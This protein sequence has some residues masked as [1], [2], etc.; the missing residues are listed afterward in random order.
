[1]IKD[2]KIG[3]RMWMFVILIGFA[4]QLAWAIENMY[5]NTYITYI[6]F[7]APAGE[8]FSYSSF[9]AITTALSAVVA[10]LTTILMGALTDKI[11]HK[12]YFISI[13][14]ILWG[15][16]T[17]AFGIFNV[18]STSKILPIAMV[19]SLAAIWVILLD[20]LMTFFGSTANDAAFNS[21]ITKNI[22][23]KNKGKVEG[24]LQILPLVAMLL[25]F[26]VLNGF[27]IDSKAGVHDAKW[28]LFFYL[29]GGLVL[30]MGILSFFLIPKEDEKKEKKSYLTELT[31]GFTPSVI[32]KNKNLYL[33]FIIYFIYAAAT[34]IFFPYLMIYL[35]Y[36]CGI[37]NTGT[38]FLTPFAIVMAVALLLGSLLSVLFGFAS[39]KVGKNK[40]II[41]TFIIYGIGIFMMFFI[42][43]VGQEQDVGRTIYGAIAGMIMILGYVGVPT[44]INAIVREKI[45]QG[46]EG[47]FMGV[48]MLFVVAFP[49]CIGPFIGDALNNTTGQSYVNEFGDRSIFPSEYGYLVGLGVLVLAILPILFYLKREKQTNKN[50]GYLFKDREHIEI[51]EKEIPL[52]SYPRPNMV[53]DSY[54]NL[55][56]MWDFAINKEE[57]I[58]SVYYDHIM[59][60]F[61]VES[62]YS[63]INHLVEP[64]E[65]MYY[66]KKVVFPKDFCKEK[67]VIH[68][69]GVDQICEVYINNQFVGKHVGGF[70]PFEIKVP[71][72]VKEEMDLV[73]KVKD[74]TDSSY[75]SRG[76]QVLKVTDFFY[77]SSSGVY[78]PVWM[79]SYPK[80]SIQEVKFT[81]DYDKKSVRVK[82]MTPVNRKAKL[83]LLNEEYEIDTNNDCEIDLSAN[84]HPWSTKDPYLY[85]VEIRYQEDVIKSY[86]GIRKIEIKNIDGK[87]RILL[88]DEPIFISGLLD[89]GYYFIGNYTPKTYDEY[90]FDIRKTKE[91]GFNCLRKH[92]KT[93]LPMFYYYCDKEG[94]LVIQDFP[95]GG[96]QYSFFWTVVPRALSFLNEKHINYK[97][98]ARESK[99]GREE[100]VKE[101]DQYLSLYHNNPSVIIYSIFN[102]GWGEFD[103]SKIYHDLKEKEKTKLFDTASG[104]YDAESDFY[105]IHTY[106]KPDMKR[107]DKKRRCFIISEM[108]GVSLKVEGHS[109]FDGMFGHG[110]AKTKEE[111]EQRYIDLYKNKMIKQ[112]GEN[113]LNMTIYTE[114][115]DCETEYNGIFTYDRKVQKIKTSTLIHINELLYEELRKVTAGKTINL[116]D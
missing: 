85:D 108:G 7:S 109:Y 70:T 113:G 65:I 112:I 66:H 20:C 71:D 42:P 77:S 22:D 53:R 38:G 43:K 6:N 54:L 93:E 116:E 29:I 10:T 80:D 35:Q 111:L 55:D 110:K 88:N 68:F 115:A 28:D 31:T 87:K 75:H 107:V 16:S 63:G 9:I 44:I 50:T 74:L 39:D 37:E 1:M 72:D 21:Y 33:I 60:P 101:C 82:V 40:M 62:A 4:G 69:E 84:F 91:L 61:A 32:K 56:G 47:S 95:C 81:P 41:P 106:S 92:I 5:L 26:V 67:T 78:K 99:E 114:L 12:K 36:T 24:V 27:T 51:D 73:L 23:K 89:Q 97:K 57:K 11:G 86:F 45:P 105:S 76:K 2:N 25:V 18:N 3:F 59:V 58:P 49:M 52:S 8:N 19:S 46:H 90:L 102:E 104:W 13:G 34:Q 17:A 48:R 14:Y 79:E 98:M 100:F 103:P 96:N 64:N 15:I 83:I 94:I 30:F